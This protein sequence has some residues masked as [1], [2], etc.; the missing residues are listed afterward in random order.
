MTAYTYT[1]D[2]RP[3]SILYGDGRSAQMEYTP[4]RQLAVVKDWLG[5]IKIERD[6]CGNPVSI[7]DHSGRTVRYEW[8][9]MGQRQGMIYPDGTKISW[10]YDSLLRRVSDG[11][12]WCTNGIGLFG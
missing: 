4:L 3:E 12:R 5:E 8:G 11:E 10:K 7:T 1:A 2:G 6:S 9:G